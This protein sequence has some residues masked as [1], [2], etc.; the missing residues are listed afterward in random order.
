MKKRILI[1]T[2]I[3]GFLPKFLMNQVRV[4]K[5]LGYEVHY[6]SNFDRP[7]YECDQEML[8]REGIQCHHIPIEK[9][10]FQ[11]TKNIKALRQL[12]ELIKNENIDVIHCNNPVGGLL[13]RLVKKRVYTIYTAHGLHFYKGAPLKNWLF[14]YPIERFLA[15]KTD[16]FITINEEDFNRVKKFRI[17]RTDGVYKIPGV[18]VDPNR[19]LPKCEEKKQIRKRLGIP[20]DTFVFL[21]VGELNQNKNH[22]TLLQSILKVKEN[23][24]KS[25]LYICGEGN[26]RKELEQFIHQ[27]H[28][29]D[30]VKLCGYQKE[31]ENYYQA[32]DVFLFPS[33][34]EGLGM[35]SLE[36]MSVGLPIIVADNRGTREYAK[37]NAIRCSA[38]NVKDFTS[39]MHLLYKDESLRRKMGN[40]SRKIAEAFSVEK[41]TEVMREIYIRMDSDLY[42]NEKI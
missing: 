21:S 12:N 20:E 23:S 26:K 7:I 31:I 18:G 16:L 28:L 8:T 42:K 25:H 11:V 3:S 27:N 17:R 34:R 40:E 13:G 24:Q 2:T 22:I 36:A 4:L 10:P 39:A 29:S 35:A 1:L 33:H 41:S 37:E 6:A 5:E 38:T 9:S 30:T 15:R 32:A 19:F 14:Y